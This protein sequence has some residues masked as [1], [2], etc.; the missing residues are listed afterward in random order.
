MLDACHALAPG[1]LVAAEPAIREA[2]D[3]PL[4]LSPSMLRLY[5]VVG[6][7]ART[8]LPVLIQGETGSGKELVARAL[9]DKSPRAKA[10]FKPL[11]CATIPANLLESV[12][13]GHER[14]AFTGA[15]RQAQ[16]VFEQA[17]GG[18][19]FLDEVGE[20]SLHAQAALLRVLEQ[21]RVVRLGGTKEIEVD[22]RVVA[23]THRD[24]AGMV[25]AGVFRADL[26]F[27]L[28]ALTLQVPPLRERRE[29]ILP[30]AALFLVRARAL[31]GSN[32]ERLSED[33]NEALSA[34]AWP[35]NVR[36]LKNVIERAVIVASGARIDLE[37]LPQQVWAEP[38]GPIWPLATGVE[39]PADGFRSLPDR[40]REFEMSI[41]RDALERAHGNQTQAARM[42][43]VPR[44]TLSNKV[45][46]YGM[47]STPE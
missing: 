36:Q 14:G 45:H 10:P 24:L 47:I 19:V 9:H 39:R 7:A 20:L 11:N 15:E 5:D 4:L 41:I 27:R 16:G 28:D 3:G 13:F 44:R 31:W 6:R 32:A 35:G 17:L 38:S 21:R 2:Q 30:L 25:R 18:T 37:D 40:V 1:S 33:A 46:A 43:G 12:L 8:T 22:I 29:D 26:M 34:Y 42:L 23:A